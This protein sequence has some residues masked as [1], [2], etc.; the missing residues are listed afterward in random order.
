ML[1]NNKVFEVLQNNANISMG[2]G[3]SSQMCMFNA[4]ATSSKDFDRMYSGSFYTITG[5][6]DIQNFIDGYTEQLE[7][8]GIGTPRDWLTFTGKDMNEHYGLTGNTA[9]PDD[10][11]FLAFPLDGLDGGKLA[12]FKLNWRDRWFDDI[13][14]NNTEAMTPTPLDDGSLDDDEIEW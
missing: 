10:L 14:D 13:V 11:T 9:Y 7:E 4:S 8:A 1:A 3:F 6:G 12:M 5:A 2:V